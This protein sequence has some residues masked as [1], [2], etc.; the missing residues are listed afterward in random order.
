[1]DRYRSHEQLV[2]L[3]R[4]SAGI[5]RLMIG[6]TL[7]VSIFL[8]L[9]VLYYRMSQSLPGWAEIQQ[10]LSKGTSAQALWLTLLNFLPLLLALA[11]VLK[12]L[13]RRSLTGLL[14]PFQNALRDFRR[15]FGAVVL[16]F[17]IVALLPFPTGVTPVQNMAFGAWAGL[18][19]VSLGLIFL[20][21][22]T[23]ELLFRGYMQSQL[24]AQFSSPAVWMLVPAVIF[25]LLHFEPA[26]YGSNAFWLA[27][28]A[29]L[30]GLAAAD[31]TA[32]SGNL[33]A[34]MALH[35]VNNISALMWTS[36][37]G[38]WD[39]LA[40]YVL[41]FGPQDTRALAGLLPGEAMIL[42]CSW[43]VARIAL[44]R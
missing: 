13:H 3:A 39:G 34:A 11:L 27:G 15:V 41:P 21:T 23:E 9:T 44:R 18:I 7:I 5:L 8:A 20:Q 17:A 43:L 12:T 22:T 38:Y 29:V 31:L 30:F 35:F 25:G 36:M 16:L 19:P 33:G 1:M 6:G 2:A 42:L 24:A 14:G 10:N 37:A 4:P 28:W 26:T 40:L 32:R